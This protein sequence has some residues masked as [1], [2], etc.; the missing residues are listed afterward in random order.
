MLF[1]DARRPFLTCESPK[2]SRDIGNAGC[3]TEEKLFRSDD[4]NL[5]Q[6]PGFGRAAEAVMAAAVAGDAATAA[7]ATAAAVAV[8]AVAS[9]LVSAASASDYGGV[10]VVAVVAAEATGA[11]V[12]A[13][14]TGAVDV[15]SIGS[16]L[17]TNA[18]G[19]SR[20]E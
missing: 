5:P 10:V 12:T 16:L 9:A 13:I 2:F 11:G 18:L 15:Y 3:R 4:G 8:A 20:P 6:V 14:G 17:K 19:E 1:Y 7:G